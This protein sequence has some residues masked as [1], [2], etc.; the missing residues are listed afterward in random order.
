[1]ANAGSTPRAAEG[2]PPVL[3]DQLE[4]IGASGL[5][6][7]VAEQLGISISTFYAYPTFNALR[8]FDKKAPFREA[9]GRRQLPRASRY[10]L[11]LAMRLSDEGQQFWCNSLRHLGASTPFYST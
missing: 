2:L 7:D 5:A 3:C 11:Q 8:V 9:F 6:S 1:M 10:F 4:P